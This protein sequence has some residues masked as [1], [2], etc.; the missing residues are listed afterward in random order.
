MKR[1]KTV[2]SGAG[3]QSA[4]MRGNT[5]G[6]QSSPQGVP[7]RNSRCMSTQRW[8]APCPSGSSRRVDGGATAQAGRSGMLP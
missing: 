3:S 1:V 4:T 6:I 8:M 2:A 5:R 7:G